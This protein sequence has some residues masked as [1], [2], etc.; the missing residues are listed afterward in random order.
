MFAY[1]RN[2]NILSKRSTA[3]TL[4]SDIEAC[5]F[6]EIV[7]RYDGDR[8]TSYNGESFRYDA[9]GNPEIYRNGNVTWTDGREMTAYKGT[10]LQYDGQGRRISKITPGTSSI[11]FTYDCN[12]FLWTVELKAVN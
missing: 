5:E 10:F 11:T 8:L 4:R 7:Y 12:I 9:I 3:F 6:E 1:D 2:G